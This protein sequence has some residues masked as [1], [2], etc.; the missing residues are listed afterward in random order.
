MQINLQLTFADTTKKTITAT[1]ADLI[2]FEAKFDLSVSRLDKEIKLTHLLFLAWHA[3]K[4]TKATE[5]EFDAWIE[6]VAAV[7]AEETKK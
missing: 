4:R 2:A 3:E 5:L 6:T 1:V 7:E